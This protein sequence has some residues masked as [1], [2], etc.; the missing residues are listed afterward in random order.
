MKFLNFKLGGVI[1]ALLGLVPIYITLLGETG[2]VKVI[3]TPE[4][5]PF[6][7]LDAAKTFYCRSLT[8]NL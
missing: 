2:H 4:E 3:G 1:L 8:S 7:G 5:S 6:S